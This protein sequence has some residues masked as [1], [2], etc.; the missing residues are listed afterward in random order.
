MTG[1]RPA[2]RAARP[3]DAPAI[4]ALHIDAWRAAYRGLVPDAV[5]DGFSVAQRTERWRARLSAEPAPG[6][7]AQRT[8]VVDD[9]RGL[10]GFALAGPARDESAPPP[11]GAG[12][13]HAIYVRPD[14]VGRGYGGALFEHAVADLV[15]RGFEPILVWVF[16]ANGRARRFYERA[17][18]Q[19]DGARAPIDF[20]DGVIVPEL[21]YRRSSAPIPAI[22]PP[23][24]EDADRLGEIQATSYLDAYATIMPPSVLARLRPER[25]AE[26]WREHLPDILGTGP[27]R[28]WVIEREGSPA[29]YALTQPAGDQFL[30]PP[31]GAGEVESLYLHPSAI[32]H[33]LGR[34]LLQHS[35]DD[36][37]A[38]GFEPLVLWAFEA[39]DRA[40]RF[41]ERAG[42]TLEVTGE[43]WVLDGIPVPIVRYRLD[44]A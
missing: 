34:A 11:D 6:P 1:R 10:A 20:G 42:W 39:N 32:G 29:G 28:V 37:H 41:Y 24:L 7:A 3:G 43:A 2:I 31:P 15:E 38:R 19:P 5:L 13:V 25:F 35:V 16:E 9:E 27:E 18:F 4:A 26:R 44:T 14:A 8:W 17:G 30:P 12:E 36:L 33:G 22:R 23:R 40:R 21:R